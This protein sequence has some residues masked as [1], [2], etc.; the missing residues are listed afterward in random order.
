MRYFFIFLIFSF[1]IFI[2]PLHFFI[3]GNDQGYGIQGFMYRYQITSQ[4][5]SF[6]PITSEIGYIT[7]GLIM[8]KSAMSI[9]SWLVGSIVFSLAF[10]IF[11]ISSNNFYKTLIYKSISV[12]IGI[13]GICL[14]FSSFFQYGLL[15][16]GPAGVSIL[17]GLPLIFIFSWIISNERIKN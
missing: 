17:I 6:I 7:S 15:F 12:L 13:S 8:G 4:G 11:L 9:L 14:I 2:C 10:F 3:I 1:L 16:N 5:N